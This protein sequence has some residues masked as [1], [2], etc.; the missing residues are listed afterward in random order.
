MCD[1][2][3]SQKLISRLFIGD[4]TAYF[5]LCPYWESEAAILEEEEKSYHLS[6]FLKAIVPV[7]CFC[8][9]FCFFFLLD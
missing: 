8:F 2:L 6:A 4:A 5:P 3:A 1:S 9:F 7:F